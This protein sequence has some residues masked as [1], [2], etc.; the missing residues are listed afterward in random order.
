MSYNSRLTV[1][2]MYRL[3]ETAKVKKIEMFNSIIS[4][5]SHDDR[6]GS[7]FDKKQRNDLNARI[8]DKLAFVL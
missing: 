2:Q 1:K 6:A 3:I 4:V 7:R 8:H 5:V